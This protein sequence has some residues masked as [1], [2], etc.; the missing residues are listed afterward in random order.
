M[1][2]SATSGVAGR[3]ASA[4]FELADTAKSLDAVAQDLT[5]FRKLVAESADLA[6]DRKST[7]LNSS[8]T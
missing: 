8:H 4:L 2:T 5:T 1:S 6:R 7:R 3:Y